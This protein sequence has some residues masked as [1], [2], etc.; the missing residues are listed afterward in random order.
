VFTHVTRI[1]FEPR[2]ITVDGATF[3]E[4]FGVRGFL[5]DGRRL[6]SRW[7]E[8]LTYRNDLVASLR[9]YFNPLDLAPALGVIGRTVGPVAVRMARRGLEPFEIISPHE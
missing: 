1:E 6:D 8:L 9:L 7:A 5:A 3:I 2:L 4:E